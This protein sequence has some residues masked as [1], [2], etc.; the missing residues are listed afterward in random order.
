M[1]H[2]VRLSW[3]VEISVRTECGNAWCDSLQG[4]QESCEA[5]A[6]VLLP[7]AMNGSVEQYLLDFVRIV[8]RAANAHT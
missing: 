6:F 8:G 1:D 2:Y 5:R 3:R 7:P 4:L